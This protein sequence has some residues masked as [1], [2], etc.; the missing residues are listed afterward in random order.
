MIKVLVDLGAKS[1]E[2]FIGENILKAMRNA[3]CVMRNEKVL[4]VT[5][6]NI[7]DLCKEIFPYEVALIPDGETSKTLQV[8][9]LPA[10]RT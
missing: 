4:V 2:I 6:K 10:S 7:L 3:Q 8:G 1:Y 5:Q 9:I